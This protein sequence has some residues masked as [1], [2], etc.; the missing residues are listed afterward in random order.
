MC[1]PLSY[2]EGFR[3]A[4]EAEKKSQVRLGKRSDEK[5]KEVGERERRRRGRR[6]GNGGIEWEKTVDGGEGG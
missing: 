1:R 6:E 3:R 2:S 5:E 4:G